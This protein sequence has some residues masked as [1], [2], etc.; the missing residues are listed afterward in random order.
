[1][2]VTS[3]SI[4]FLSVSVENTFDHSRSRHVQGEWLK[5]GDVISSLLLRRAENRLRLKRMGSICWVRSWGDNFNDRTEGES[6]CMI[7]LMTRIDRLK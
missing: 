3:K 5:D 6:T 2:C 4:T 7:W 1:M